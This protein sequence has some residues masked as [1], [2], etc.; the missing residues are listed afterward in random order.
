MSCQDYE[1][2]TMTG[3]AHGSF[4][5]ERTYNSPPAR[6]YEAWT[7]P[8]LKARWFVGPPGWTQIK[9]ELDVR[10]GAVE[11][12]Q[13]RIEAVETLF[14]AR[15]HD[16]VPGA[17]LVYA[18]D[19]HLSGT[20]HSVS[21]AAVEFRAEGAGTKLVF[22]EHV[23]FLDGTEGVPGTASREHGTAAHLDRIPGVL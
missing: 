19:M 14:T 17:R 8:E 10:E 15:Y 22:T 5:I 1:I 2:P 16:V 9:R 7:N 4:T 23:V 13:G 21:V 6:V 20:H 3:V 12:L 11:V 18:Y